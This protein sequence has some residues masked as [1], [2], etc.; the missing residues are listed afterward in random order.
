MWT[1][2]K[3]N[4][5]L[6][7]PSS[8]LVE[9]MARLPGDILV[10][11][12]GGKMGPSLC[13]L[14]RRAG[15]RVA[16]V[17][18]FSGCEERNYLEEN[19][20][21]TIAADLLDPAQRAA[22]PQMENVVFM[23]GRKF[24]TQG[25]EWLTWAMNASLPAFIAE[26]YRA[27]RIVAFSS[28][29]VYP[30]ASPPGCTEQTPPEPVGEYAMSC[31]ARERAFEFAAETYGTKVL[32]YRLNYATDLRYGVLYDIA[33]NILEGRPVSL[34]TPC[35]NLIWQG[36]ANEIALRALLHAQS[37][38]RKLNVTGPEVLS[39]KETALR[40]GEILGKEPLFE[41]EEGETA[42]L[43]DASPAM[44]LFGPPG[45]T[46][47]TLIEWQARWLLDGGGGPGK[48]THFEERKGRY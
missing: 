17:S 16:A 23:A 22:L 28:G 37:P 26:Q 24:G 30:L 41:G 48:P 36:S 44:E 3:L 6:T 19:G 11:G 43:S 38:A 14:A 25:R 21:E 18:R 33:E 9:D 39:V 45:V 27:S 12:A 15:K 40:L 31:L 29:N 46:A 2:E 42:L 5:L 1:E 34:R 32:L 47:G 20:V 13:V 35:F 10:L 7:T 8:A 4:D